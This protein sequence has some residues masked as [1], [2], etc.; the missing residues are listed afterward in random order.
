MSRDNSDDR[1]G[2]LACLADAVRRLIDVTVTIDAPADAV[3]AAAARIDGLAD[4][5]RAF[6]PRREDCTPDAVKAAI[7]RHTEG[8]L[9]NLLGEARVNVVELN[10]D[11]DANTQR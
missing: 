9:F 5:L 11:L 4:E 6:I 8:R 2:A 3:T 7:A 1:D 10:L